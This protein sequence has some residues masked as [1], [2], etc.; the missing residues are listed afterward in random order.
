MGGDSRNHNRLFLFRRCTDSP[1]NRLEYRREHDCT[2]RGR[3]NRSHQQGDGRSVPYRCR[4]REIPQRAAVS[5]SAQRRRAVYV[6]YRFCGHVP[7]GFRQGAK[8]VRAADTLDLRQPPQRVDR[9]AHFDAA[10]GAHHRRLDI[11]DAQHVVRCRR[12]WGVQRRV[13]RRQGEGPDVRQGQFHPR[14]IQGCCG[15]GR[16]QGG[17]NGDCGL[18]AQSS[19]IQGIGRQ[20][21]QRGASGRPS[22][23]G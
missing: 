16:G 10:V 5:Q 12:R 13:Q 17:D 4:R 2:G 14:D 19:K 6:Q 9:P 22:R 8:P 1:E 11:R 7:S 21:T 18:F 3:K 23:D 15:S 20:D